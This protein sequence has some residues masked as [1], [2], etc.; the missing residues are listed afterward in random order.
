MS[1]YAF[2]MGQRLFTKVQCSEHLDDIMIYEY[3]DN[4]GP[5]CLD[6][7]AMMMDMV[8]AAALVCLTHSHCDLLLCH[9]N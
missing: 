4:I 5:P 1:V 9:E 3:R 8:S 7:V 2:V 6:N